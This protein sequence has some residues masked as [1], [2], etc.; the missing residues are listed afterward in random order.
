MKGLLT[1]FLLVSLAA[2][3]VFYLKLRGVLTESVKSEDSPCLSGLREIAQRLGVSTRD[4][5]SD[6][7][8]MSDICLRLDAAELGPREVLS[9]KSISELSRY[10][11]ESDEQRL[12]SINDFSAKFAG[13]RILVIPGK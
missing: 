2:N 3:G 7:E 10:A 5:R 9:E 8:L 4:G 1:L 11:D 12:R 6:V 13:R